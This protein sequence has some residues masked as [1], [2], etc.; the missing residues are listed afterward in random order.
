MVAEGDWEISDFDETQGY[1][2]TDGLQIDIESASSWWNSENLEGKSIIDGTIVGVVF[3]NQDTHRNYVPLTNKWKNYVKNLLHLI[4][5]WTE[6]CIKF[7]DVSDPNNKHRISQN[8][9]TWRGLYQKDMAYVWGK[10]DCIA[11][12]PYWGRTDDNVITHELFHC[13]ARCNK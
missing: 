13:F 3:W 5:E 12:F 11:S 4:T 8:L 10:G 1:R 7:L 9:V 2:S 6:G